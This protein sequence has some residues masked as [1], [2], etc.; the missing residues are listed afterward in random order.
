M[1]GKNVAYFNLKRGSA[2]KPWVGTT[3]TTNETKQIARKNLRKEL[4]ITANLL[5]RF[6]VSL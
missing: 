1:G 3:Q 2:A 5:F 6:N 4:F